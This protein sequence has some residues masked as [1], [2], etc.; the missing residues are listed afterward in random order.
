[1]EVDVTP[2]LKLFRPSGSPIILIFLTPAPI[3]NSQVKPFSGGI[4]YTGGRKYWRFSSNFWRKSPFI[5][6]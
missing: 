3:P 2:I 6:V 5:S 1:M 4:K